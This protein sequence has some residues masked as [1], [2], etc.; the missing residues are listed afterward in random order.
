MN[1]L[2]RNHAMAALIM[3]VVFVCAFDA[4]AQDAAY[5]QVAA[6]A[7]TAAPADTSKSEAPGDAPLAELIERAQQN[8]PEVLIAEAQLREAEARLQQARLEA[9]GKVTQIYFDRAGLKTMKRTFSE[10]QK[11]AEL[12]IATHEEVAEAEM[13]LSQAEAKV[14]SQEAYLE[15]LS[16]R[17]LTEKKEADPAS[18]KRSLV[19]AK[20]IDRP[21][22]PEEFRTQ[23]KMTAKSTSLTGTFTSDDLTLYLAEQ[24]NV[25][26]AID[27]SLMNIAFQVN[28]TDSNPSL[29][30]LLTALTDS[31]EVCFI[32]RD[33]G[34]FM[35]SIR[36]AERTNAPAIPEDL[37]L[38][39]NTFAE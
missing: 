1:R 10:I 24:F 25:N 33:Y 12:G 3:M 15:V 7:P 28:L 2:S 37:P 39:E 4:F 19:S 8:S 13:R 27:V 36:R 30:N 34:L 9:V 16:K 14:T 38:Y 31:A 23:L 22:L 26:L 20:R 11:K 32:V 29:G 5:P 35:T 18:P 6:P 21:K 17:A